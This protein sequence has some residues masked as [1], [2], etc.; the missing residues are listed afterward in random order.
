MAVG[1][2]GISVNKNFKDWTI[3]IDFE[4]YRVTMLMSDKIPDN[5]YLR[6]HNYEVETLAA[7]VKNIDDATGDTLA[8]RV[9]IKNGFSL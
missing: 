4:G 6:H 3:S 8:F 1:D 7:F 9:F 5:Q 2:Y